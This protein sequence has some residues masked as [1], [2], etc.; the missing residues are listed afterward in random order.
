[1]SRRL[2]NHPKARIHWPS[3]LRE[4]EY[5]ADLVHRREPNVLDVIGFTDGL[6]LPIQCA[7]DPI[8]RN[9]DRIAQYYENVEDKDED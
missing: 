7:T 1:M 2:K 6:S 8:I 4:K 5:L 9:Y 3:T